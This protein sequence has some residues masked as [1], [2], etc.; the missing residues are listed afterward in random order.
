MSHIISD[1]ARE[2]ETAVKNH[3]VLNARKR[4]TRYIQCKYNLNAKKARKFMYNVFNQRV[5]TREQTEFKKFVKFNPYFKSEVSENMS[6]F[7]QKLWEVLQVF[8]LPENKGKKGVKMF[9]LLPKKSDFITSFMPI[10]QSYLPHIL[11]LLDREMQLYIMGKL[12]AKKEK[13][14][15]ETVE[16]L[17]ARQRPGCTC[18]FGDELHQHEDLSRELWTLLFPGIFKL[19]TVNR[20]FWFRLSTNGYAASVS[21]KKPIVAVEMKESIPVEETDKVKASDF[22]PLPD[23]FKGFTSFIGIDPG[24]KYVATACDEEGKMTKVSTREYH[25]HATMIQRKKWERKFRQKNQEYSDAIKGLPSLKTADY[26]VFCT[27]VGLV[28]GGFHS[29][30][31]M[32]RRP[33]F[34]AW[35]FKSAVVGQKAMHEMAKKIVGKN[36][37]KEDVCVG[38][39]DWSQQDGFLR[40]SE[41]APVKKLR[42][43]LRTMATVVKIDEYCTSQT[44]SE[45]HG[46]V[47]NM[48]YPKVQEDGKTKRVKCHEVVCCKNNKCAIYWQRDRNASRN[49]HALLKCLVEGKERPLAMRRRQRA[50]HVDVKVEQAVLGTRT[51][52]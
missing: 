26:E 21:M 52:T 31:E 33:A 16:Y 13:F 25:H 7:I 27:R 5:L 18:V 46:K 32:S 50:L 6:H 37:K 39:G 36:K 1:A 30:Y 23:S 42:A 14:R 49:I 20:K 2:I 47:K 44:C 9:T 10:T 51:S 38:F 11:K 15:K 4:F 43:A 3:I 41:K 17:E 40:G 19:E 28:L 45:C 22:D 29:L 48:Y 8:E 12:L 35:R 24:R 34:R